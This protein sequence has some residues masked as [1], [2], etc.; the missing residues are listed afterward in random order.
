MNFENF[1]A[2]VEARACVRDFLPDSLPLEQIQ[3]VLR[4]ASRAPSSKNTQPW[5]AILVRGEALERLRQAYVQAFEEGV[6]P[7]PDYSYSVEP[8]PDVWKARARQVGFALFAHKGIA[9]EDKDKMHQHYKDN[10]EFFGAPQV[11]FITTRKDAG[12]GNFMDIGMFL[13]NVLNGITAKGWAACPS[14]SA[15]VYPQVLRA[16]LGACEEDLFVCGVPFGIASDA[17]VNSYRTVRADLS[18]WVTVL[19]E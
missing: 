7:S 15:A 9:R 10:F 4:T 1:A 17:H 11:L 8:Q 3:E 16:H 19:E 2:V 14:M 12:L 18:E 5:K 13:A 6:K